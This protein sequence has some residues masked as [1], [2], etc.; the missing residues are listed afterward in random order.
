MTFLLSV[1]A[2][3]THFMLQSQTTLR[4]PRMVI[5]DSSLPRP[6]HHLGRCHICFISCWPL[7]W[8]RGLPGF[9]T[10][11][12]RTHSHGYM[13]FGEDFLYCHILNFILHLE[14]DQLEWLLAGNIFPA[15]SV[16]NI[17]TMNWLAL[18]VLSKFIKSIYTGFSFFS[19]FHFPVCIPAGTP[20][21]FVIFKA[22]YC[23]CHLPFHMYVCTMNISKYTVFHVC[24]NTYGCKQ[25]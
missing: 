14:L 20:W 21:N 4:F 7:L 19:L 3:L 12:Y 8:V 1:E 17:L 15:Y 11:Y 18:G 24:G 5:S 6:L 9:Y 23:F 22:V 10:V 25:M 13:Y 2:D 16:L